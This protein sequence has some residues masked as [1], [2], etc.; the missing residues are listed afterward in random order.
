MVR[1][2]FGTVHVPVRLLARDVAHLR[3]HH[4]S[5]ITSNDSFLYSSSSSPSAML[6]STSG[7]HLS[8]P[9]FG[10][11]ESSREPAVET[12]G[13]AQD[14]RGALTVEVRDGR[15]AVERRSLPHAIDPR[16]ALVFV[17]CVCR[18]VGSVRAAG[19][20]MRWS[21]ALQASTLQPFGDR[22]CSDR[23]P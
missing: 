6:S 16:G 19:C 13:L 10:R 12:R 2:R 14:M 7:V 15:A 8:L 9:V 11:R 21:K 20:N 22:S 1:S 18:A 3:L 4:T 23:Y 5:H 17:R